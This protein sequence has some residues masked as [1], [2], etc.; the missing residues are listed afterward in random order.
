[1]FDTILLATCLLATDVF[2]VATNP[3]DEQYRQ[4]ELYYFGGNATVFDET[5][6]FDPDTSDITEDTDNYISGTVMDPA[7]D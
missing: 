1:M 7:V 2:G 5:W 6:H 3:C 4:Q